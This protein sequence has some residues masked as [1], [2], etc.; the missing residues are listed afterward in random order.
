MSKKS[1]KI[2]T[3]PSIPE[4]YRTLNRDASRTKQCIVEDVHFQFF[5]F[6][7]PAENHIVSTGVQ[8]IWPNFNKFAEMPKAQI[9][10]YHAQL[11]KS[12][13]PEGQDLVTSAVYVWYKL[14]DIATDRTIK[15][16][17]DPISGKRSTISASTYS[18]GSITDVPLGLIKTPQASACYKIFR[19]TL[20]TAESITEAKLKE[21]IMARAGELK[22]RQDPWRIFQYY[23]P[24]LI[25]LNVLRRQG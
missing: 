12:E 9:L 3:V 15:T 17:T 23:R 16:P 7:T 25:K 8:N 13:P 10:T 6:N 14:C 5:R 22:T 20:D 2:Q 24:S 1:K 21:A 18:L 4:M 19:E 11:F